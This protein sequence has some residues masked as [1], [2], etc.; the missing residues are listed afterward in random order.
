[1]NRRGFV[2]AMLTLGG[3]AR[4]FAKSPSQN[5]DAPAPSQTGLLWDE[6]YL[7]H[8]AGDTGHPDDPER[9][10]AIRAGLE[11]AGLLSA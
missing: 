7:R 4:L 3:S 11:R 2:L 8:L 6:V 10:T 1:M 5:A 9:L